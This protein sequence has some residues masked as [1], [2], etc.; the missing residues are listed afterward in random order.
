MSL[1]VDANLL[2][3]ASDRQSPFHE[4]ARPALEHLVGGS[5]IIYLFWPVIMAYVRIATHPSIFERP[6]PPERARTNIEVLLARPNVVAPGESDGFWERFRDVASEADARGNLV[7]DAHVV[8]LMIQ[9]G[10][11]T[12]WS[13]DRD[14]RRFSGI[15]VHD[16]FAG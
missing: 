9:H 6:M 2:L 8:A 7:T 1:A 16:P 10:V 14:Y 12:I 13:N 5:D 4:R 11:R 15:E 3:H